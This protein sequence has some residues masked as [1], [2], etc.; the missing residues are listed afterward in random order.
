MKSPFLNNAPSRSEVSLWDPQVWTP[1]RFEAYQQ[2][3]AQDVTEAVRELVRDNLCHSFV[4]SIDSARSRLEESGVRRQL[5]RLNFIF[6]AQLRGFV[7]ESLKDWIEY[8]SKIA[9]SEQRGKEEPHANV[10]VSVS[11]LLALQLQVSEG[12][13]FLSPP[14]EE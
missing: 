4:H 13:A 8:F 9:D 1:Q 12:K 6:E 3:V 10:A 11:P 7:E 14:T 2:A 5:Q